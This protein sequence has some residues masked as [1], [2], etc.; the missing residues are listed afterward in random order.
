[1][2][3]VSA[4]VV[5]HGHA[6]ALGTLLPLLVPLVDELVVVANH[7]GSLPAEVPP[8][9]RVIEN[10][11]PRRLAENVNPKLMLRLAK[12]IATGGMGGEKFIPVKEDRDYF[13]R[14]RAFAQLQLSE[15]EIKE[16]M[17]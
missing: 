9:A 10:P 8:G 2:T 6:R 4:V 17:E 11:V 5:S 14:I 3:D 12:M 15:Q 13:P 7:P 16:W 1:M